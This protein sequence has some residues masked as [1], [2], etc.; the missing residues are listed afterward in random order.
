MNKLKNPPLFYKFI[1][2]KTYYI[3]YDLYFNSILYNDK[4]CMFQKSY[5]QILF[6]NLT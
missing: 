6:L 2:V 4:F 3:N 5:K 1:K